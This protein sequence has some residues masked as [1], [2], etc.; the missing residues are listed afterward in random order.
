M[1]PS[2]IDLV[3][4]MNQVIWYGRQSIDRGIKYVISLVD[5]FCR[6]IF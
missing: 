3:G 6:L 2:I 5:D 4:T 1:E